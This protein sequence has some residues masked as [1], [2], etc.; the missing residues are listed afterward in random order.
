MNKTKQLLVI[1]IIIVL[2]GAWWW[3]QNPV[4]LQHGNS[5]QIEEQIDEQNLETTIEVEQAVTVEDN[6]QATTIVVVAD[7]E[8]KTVF[9]LLNE[10]YDIEYTEYDFGVFIE[11]IEGVAGD[12]GHFWS[13]YVND[14]LSPTGADQTTVSPD[15]MV[16]FRYEEIK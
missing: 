5:A 14:E 13:L 7:Q 11:S 3:Q 16:E 15:D 2:G 10:Q 9:E 6:A 12:Q 8:G 1:G 4:I